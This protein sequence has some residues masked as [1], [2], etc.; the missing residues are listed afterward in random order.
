MP[1]AGAML[2]R[3]VR[4]GVDTICDVDVVWGADAVGWV[5]AMNRVPTSGGE[6][7]RAAFRR[8]YTSS[9]AKRSVSAASSTDHEE[10]R[11]PTGRALSS[12]PP[13]MTMETLTPRLRSKRYVL[14]SERL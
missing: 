12:R 2:G 7:G 5:D 1:G 6:A 9:A 8:R 10:G 13:T 3:G 11:S 4:R 14:S